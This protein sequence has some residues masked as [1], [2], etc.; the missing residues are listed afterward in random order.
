MSRG[1]LLKRGLIIKGL[2]EETKLIK[3]YEECVIHKLHL[4]FNN[5]VDSKNKHMKEKEINN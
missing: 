4:H 2:E 1:S 3:K 5:F